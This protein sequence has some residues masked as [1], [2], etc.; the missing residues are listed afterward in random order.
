MSTL[1]SCAALHHLK[2]SR[3]EDTMLI[4]YRTD[5]TI[6]IITQHNHGLLSGNIAHILRD[7]R[8]GAALHHRLILAIS[9]HDLAWHHA[10][11]P[12]HAESLSWNEDEGLPHS[13]MTA[14][15]PPKL[16]MY[17]KGIDEIEALDS[18]AALLVSHHYGAFLG[19]PD[20]AELDIKDREDRRRARLA[21]QLGFESPDDPSILEDFAWLKALD[22]ISIFACQA[23]PGSDP[24]T[25]PSWIKSS[26]RALD[27]DFTF[28]FVDADD[29]VDTIKLI[30]ADVDKPT[31][32]ELPYME[33]ERRPYERSEFVQAWEQA[34]LKR[35][36]LRIM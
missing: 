14:P 26:L 15:R 22:L 2:L 29:G 18:Y 25:V 27:Q 1:A 33:F 23:A 6:R 4:Q 36:P 31:V 20:Q 12:P 34:E 9:M 7:A 5:D 32:I 28:D 8:T 3:N 21:A 35:W 16:I 24:A 19:G 11:A 10:D 30:G 17:T 13:F